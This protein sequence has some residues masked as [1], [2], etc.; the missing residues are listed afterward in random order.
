MG[1]TSQK[2]ACTTKVATS[3]LLITIYDYPA[4]WRK[5]RSPKHVCYSVEDL[6]ETMLL[7]FKLTP[8]G[9]VTES[10]VHPLLR[11]KPEFL[12]MYGPMRDGDNHIRYE[13]VWYH[14]ATRCHD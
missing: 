5:Y 12:F 6:I 9:V 14:Q 1:S 13:T 2:Q 3:E 4:V 11:G 7:L 8:S 10:F